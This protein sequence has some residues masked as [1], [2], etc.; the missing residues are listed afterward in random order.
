M[1]KTYFPGR[2]LALD[3]PPIDNACGQSEQHDGQAK[4]DREKGG[5]RDC[6]APDAG[7]R[8][9]IKQERSRPNRHR[10]VHENW[11]QRMA[12]PFTL[13]QIG[14]HRHSACWTMAA[15]MPV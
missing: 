9:Q 4:A 15:I 1:P 2:F 11:V 7:S 3:S 10:H 6:I 14:D 13:E 8:E 5:P 12:Q